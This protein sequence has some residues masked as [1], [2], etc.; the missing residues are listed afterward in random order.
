MIAQRFKRTFSTYPNLSRGPYAL[1]SRGL[2]HVRV[3]PESRFIEGDE[4]SG[5]PLGHARIRRELTIVTL[6]PRLI[7]ANSP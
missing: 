4:A 1:V 6:D 2:L 3:Y 5:S 7:E